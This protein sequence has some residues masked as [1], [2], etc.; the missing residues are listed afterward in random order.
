MNSTL[1][2]TIFRYG[3]VPFMLFGLN[4]AAW[5]VVAH[6]HSYAWLVPLLGAA[7][8]ITFLA[9]R[10]V[11]FHEEWNH[12]HGDD[13]AN[14]WHMIVYEGTNTIGVLTIPL[15][16][17]LF[18]ITPGTVIGLWPREWPILAQLA[19]AIVIADFIFTTI[20][21]LSHRYSVLWRLHAVHH[22]VSRLYGFNGL[23]RHPLHQGLDM[24]IGTAPMAIVGMPVEVA[25]LLGFAVSIQLIVQHSNVDAALG[26]VRNQLSIGRIHHLHHVNWGKEGDV[27]FGLFLTL[28]DRV[29]GTFVPE[30]SRPIR[31]NDMGIDEVPDFPKSYR[32]H[33]VFP[34]HYKPGSGDVL[35]KPAELPAAAAKPRPL[36]DAAE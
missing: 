14:V 3:Y 17:W 2:R 26:P 11:P 35:Q 21:Y 22:G 33:L 20:H 5:Y 9:E 23:V 12:S 25:A 15:T 1:L 8:A 10:V 30:P 29:F 19:L 36:H 16:V 31:A 34:F 24:L 27:N 18:N 6:G 28:W 4:G 13:A 32:E 7:F